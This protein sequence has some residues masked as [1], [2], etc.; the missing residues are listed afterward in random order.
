M[1]VSPGGARFDAVEIVAFGERAEALGFD[2]I[3]LSDVPMGAIGDPLV[4]LTYIAGR[5][6]RLKLGA[7]VVPVGR[8]PMLLARELAQIDQLSDGRLLLAMVPGLDQPGERRALGFATGDRGA[9]VETTTAL[10]R[11]WWSGERVDHHDAHADFDDVAVAPVPYQKPLEVWMGGKGPKAL[12]RVARAADGW[13]TANVTPDE[14]GRGR[15]TIAARAEALG[16][17]IDDEHYGISVPYA[18]SSIP[19]PVEE[20]LRAR[21]P[22]GSITDIAPIGGGALTALVGQHIERGL[23][24]FVLRPL[25]GTDPVEDLAW[26]ADTV[27][28]LQT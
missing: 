19:P 28:P 25:D 18:R 10:M 15:D 11:R 21:R 22:D 24:K 9:L 6:S 17:T 13:L 7:N 2:T 8:N 16:R 3:W 14:A 1:A 20:A 12:E 27:I 23:S 26:L 4:S 5:T